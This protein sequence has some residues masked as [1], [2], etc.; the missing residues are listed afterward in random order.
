MIRLGK[1]AVRSAVILV[2]L[3]TLVTPGPAARQAGPGPAGTSATTGP[4]I[5][6]AYRSLQ[7][8]EPVLV[9]LENDG[10]VRSASASLLGKTAELRATPSSRTTRGPGA[11]ISSLF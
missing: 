10:T 1:A 9:F 8:G 5:R 2:A 4:V 11:G 7:P 6:L 3:A